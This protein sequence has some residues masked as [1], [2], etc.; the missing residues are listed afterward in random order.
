MRVSRRVYALAAPR[1]YCEVLVTHSNAR[2]L[3]IG[4]TQHSNTSPAPKYELLSMI[5]LLTIPKRPHKDTC[6]HLDRLAEQNM[7]QDR[8]PSR[9]LSIRKRFGDYYHMV[10]NERAYAIPHPFLVYLQY[11]D[12]MHLC[13]QMPVMDRRLEEFLFSSRARRPDPISWELAR[14]QLRDALT[15]PP[16]INTY[17]SKYRFFDLFVI[18]SKRVT[19]RNRD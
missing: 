12:V 10:E 18:P 4:S 19:I 17:Y 16:Q 13:I 11:L 7:N 8:L 9:S 6:E 14:R 2:S 1:L 5:R 3:F 15:S